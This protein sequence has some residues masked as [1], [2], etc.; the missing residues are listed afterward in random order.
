M[1]FALLH[2]DVITPAQ[3]VESGFDTINST[4][5]FSIPVSDIENLPQTSNVDIIG[6]WV[7]R[8]DHVSGNNAPF[9]PV[10]YQDS[11]DPCQSNTNLTAL[12]LQYPFLYFGHK[13]NNIYVNN[14]GYLTFEPF[15]ESLPKAFPANS[16]RDI[17]APLWAKFGS[18]SYCIVTQGHILDRAR[19]DIKQYFPQFGFSVYTVFIATWNS[20]NMESSFQVVLVICSTLSFVIMNYGNISSTDQRFQVGQNKNLPKRH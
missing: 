8:V 6:R 10:G 19:N 14:N 2:Y 3:S 20:P 13:Y 11:Q 16:T 4:N 7:F 12:H 9:Y 18:I 5:F 1:S 17:I 15:Y